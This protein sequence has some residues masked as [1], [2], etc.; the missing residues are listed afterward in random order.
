[1]IGGIDSNEWLH[2]QTI[3]FDLETEKLFYESTE[4]ITL[5]KLNNPK[6]QTTSI[7]VDN[8]IYC[9]FGKKKNDNAWPPFKFCTEIEWWK[10][11]TKGIGE[12]KFE[13]L[14]IKWD[15]KIDK[16]LSPCIISNN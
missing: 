4:S 9:F 6:D 10:I 1:L 16:V 5:P 2:D 11:P 15:E 13:L 3:G 14:E 7:V 8:T 12:E